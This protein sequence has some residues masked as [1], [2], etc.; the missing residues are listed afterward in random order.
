MTQNHF[1]S[2][3]KRQWTINRQQEIFNLDI[4]QNGERCIQL[5][6]PGIFAQ[7]NVFSIVLQLCLIINLV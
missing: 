5:N 4:A 1:H 2:V 7:L 3:K 6:F